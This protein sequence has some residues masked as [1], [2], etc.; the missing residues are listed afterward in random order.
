MVLRSMINI[1]ETTT[2]I[3]LFVCYQTTEKLRVLSGDS[4]VEMYTAFQTV[5]NMG[6]LTL[7]WHD[8]HNLMSFSRN[9]TSNHTFYRKFNAT[10]LQNSN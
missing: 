4:R 7:K 2:S 3:E 1:Y 8:G 5:L 10:W 9:V 6:T